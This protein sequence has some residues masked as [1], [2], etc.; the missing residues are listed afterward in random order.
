MFYPQP[1]YR[2]GGYNEKE[3][4]RGKG[5]RVSEHVVL[6]NKNIPGRSM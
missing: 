2:M 3:I 6:S 4:F 5:K 1:E